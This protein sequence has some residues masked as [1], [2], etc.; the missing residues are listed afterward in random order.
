MA[1]YKRDQGRTAR[2]V[3]FWALLAVAYFGAT[4]LKSFLTGFESLGKPLVESMK[5]VPILGAPLNAAFLL[6]VLFFAVVGYGVYRWSER[7]KTADLLIETE[8]E[9]R[10]V[11]WPSVP[12]VVNSSLVVVF[13]VLFLMAF[14]AG[15]D[16]FLARISRVLLFG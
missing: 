8:A 11:T 13:C 4:S 15:A 6:G 1:G 16:W 9:L 3:E 5:R 2:T 12:E 7:A 14:L 10:K